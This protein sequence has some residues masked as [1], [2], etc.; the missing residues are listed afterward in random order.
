MFAAQMASI[1]AHQEQLVMYQQENVTVATVLQK[2]FTKVEAQQVK[3]KDVECPGGT[4][5]CPNGST[6]CKLSSGQYGCC[7][8]PNAVCCSDGLHCCPS[9]TTCGVSAGQCNLGNSVTE[10]FTKVEANPVESKVVKCPGGKQG[11]QDG[12]TCCLLKT[13]QYGCCPLPKAICCLDR[14]HCCPAGYKCN[15]ASATCSKADKTLPW[16][17]KLEAFPLEADV[18]QAV[19]EITQE[20]NIPEDVEIVGQSV[21]CPD[22]QSECPSGNTCCHQKTG[23][24][25]CC[26]LPSAVCCDDKI[27]CCPNG[28]T[29]DPSAGTC[30][31]GLQSLPW[32]LKEPARKSEPNVLCGDS[33]TSCP[34]EDTCCML[35]DGTYG[36][37]PLK[38]AVCCSDHLHCCPQ[39]S[40]CD[41]KSGKCTQGKISIPWV[42]KVPGIPK[43]PV[44]NN[45]PGKTEPAVASV[46]CPDGEHECADGNTCCQLL[47]GRWGCCPFPQA[48]CCSDHFHC[49]P[50]GYICDYSR[51]TCDRGHQSQQLIRLQRIP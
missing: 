4:A 48:V 15:T 32:V 36:C 25:G 35:S 24:Y 43:S 27:H 21:K 40:T 6:C 45:A 29:C 1:V 38:N 18:N 19:V 5:T 37:C 13:G 34:G 11:C 20:Q 41:L 39:G 2:W 51:S 50:N 30:N 17:N 28:Y 47:S 26:P 7:P 22:G 33:K 49:C 9:G 44:E 16:F 10:W 46:M 42:N 31:A 3:S 12:N 23:Q 8:L 14:Q